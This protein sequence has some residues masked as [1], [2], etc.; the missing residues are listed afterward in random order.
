MSNYVKS[1]VS[2]VMPTYKRSEMLT[3]A[4]ESVLSQTYRNI[5]LIL[6]NDN[7]PY[8]DY[9]EQ[10][11][12]CVKRYTI[13]PRFHLIIQEKH[14]NGAVARNV[15][16]RSAVGEYIAFLDDDDWWEKN[17]IEEQVKELE[18]LDLS[19]G[20]VSCKFTL[21]DQNG[22]VLGKSQKY[23]DGYIY[24]DILFLLSDVATGTLLLRREL[25]DSTR[26]FDET[27]LRHQDLQLLVDFTFKF[28]LKEV[29][30]YLHCVDV[31][32]TRNRPDPEKLIKYK[33]AF[34]DSIQPIMETLNDKERKCIYAMHKFE[35]GYTCIK[36]KEFGRG[37]KYCLAV[38]ESPTSVVLAMKKTINK[39]AQLRQH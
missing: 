27:L 8:D 16:I 25:F 2:V 12:E 3:R 38:F 31:S 18:K 23:K 34:F 36:N 20:G 32:D 19:W 15:G 4:I 1:L 21:F 7:E 5:E 6:V 39:M 22:N 17:K 9:T 28:K 26:Y 29:D 24:K 13:D 10:L 35:L 11:K 30:K 14:I 33:K 37:L